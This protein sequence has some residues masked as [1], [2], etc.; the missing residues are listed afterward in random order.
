MQVRIEITNFSSELVKFE[1][2]TFE[3]DVTSAELADLLKYYLSIFSSL[4]TKE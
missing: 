4:T 3:N 1:Q 2:L